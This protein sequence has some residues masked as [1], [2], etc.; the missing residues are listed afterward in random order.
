MLLFGLQEWENN[1][2]NFRGG[3]IRSIV[4]D[5]LD[6]ESEPKHISVIAQFVLT[7]RPDTYE[8]SILDN[9][10]ADET[11]T[12]VFFKNSVIGLSSKTYDD[13]FVRL[14]PTASTNTN[15]EDP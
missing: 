14:G 3:T 4:A 5:F 11:N 10:K 2:E 15:V 12:F 13:S 7:Y 6:G 8:R 1:L 9:L